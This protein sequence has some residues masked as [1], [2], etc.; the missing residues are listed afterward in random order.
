MDD[1]IS[2]RSKKVEGKS[3][4]VAYLIVLIVIVGSRML[5]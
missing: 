5:R 1:A 4:M 2:K 3:Q